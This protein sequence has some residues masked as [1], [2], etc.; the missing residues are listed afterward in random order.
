MGGR[1]ARVRART[2]R[3]DGETD[4]QQRFLAFVKNLGGES[5]YVTIDLDCLRAEDAVTNWENGRFTLDDVEWALSEL[6]HINRIIAGDICGAFSAADLRATE[7]TFRRGNRSSK[8]ESAGVDGNPTHQYRGVETSL[9][10][11]S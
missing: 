7:A 1:T 3:R 10:S 9:A 4:W 6:R 5:V 11:P 8:A 2:S